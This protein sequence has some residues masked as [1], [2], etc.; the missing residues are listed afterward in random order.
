MTR[1][2]LLLFDLWIRNQDRTLTPISGN[3]NLLWGPAGMAVI[4]HNV[5]FDRDFDFVEFSRGHVFS[6]GLSRMRQN[7]SVRRSYMDRLLD[8]AQS[9]ERA[10]SGAPQD[11]WYFD[12]EHT[13]ATDFDVTEARDSLQRC[14]N[15]EFWEMRT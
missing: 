7:V 12:A 6:E 2:G 4:D 8:A 15:D 5:A 13:V 1:R 10:V 9:W 3:P 14:V 11:W